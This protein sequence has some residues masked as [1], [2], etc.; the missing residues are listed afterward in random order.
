MQ[1]NAHGES[2]AR[3]I[4]S[5][6]HK[7]TREVLSSLDKDGKFAILYLRNYK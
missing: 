5:A 6:K 2:V 4:C 7:Q 1:A 3:L